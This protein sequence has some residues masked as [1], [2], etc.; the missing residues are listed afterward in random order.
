MGILIDVLGVVIALC[1]LI[2]A[3]STWRGAT[4]LALVL[5]EC[6]TNNA[7]YRRQHNLRQCEMGDAMDA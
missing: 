5:A 4:K 1:S 3:V 7:F 2:T 6:K